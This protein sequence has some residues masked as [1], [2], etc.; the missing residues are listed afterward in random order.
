MK[1]VIQKVKEAKVLVD[2][3]IKAEIKQGFVL[4]VGI[5]KED[6]VIDT[7]KAADKI[8]KI[9]LFEDEDGKTNLSLNDVGGEILSISQFTLAADVRK[10]NRPSFINAMDPETANELF[11]S[12][13][14]HLEEHSL[15]VYTGVFQ[16]HMNVILDNDGPMTIVMEVKDGKVL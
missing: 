1:I 5:E 4:F 11:N 9:R 15:N 14:Q 6:T 2:N 10:G 7:K 16:A 8:S 13:N 3:L 12:F